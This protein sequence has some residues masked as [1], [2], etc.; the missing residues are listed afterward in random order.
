MAS[1]GTGV[2]KQVSGKVLS[3]TALI[4]RLPIGLSLR[5]PHLEKPNSNVQSLD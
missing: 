3:S 2:G 1:L 4:L 5:C